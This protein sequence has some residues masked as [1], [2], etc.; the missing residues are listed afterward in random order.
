MRAREKIEQDLRS[1]GKID[2]SSDGRSASGIFL[3]IDVVEN[4]QILLETMLD[5]RD[6]LKDLKELRK[7]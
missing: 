5:I 7:S 4:Q 6:L 2:T 1:I 3:L